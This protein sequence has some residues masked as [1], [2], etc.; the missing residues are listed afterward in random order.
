[1]SSKRAWS[2]IWTDINVWIL[3]SINTFNWFH[4]IP[5][6]ELSLH[7]SCFWSSVEALLSDFYSK[8]HN[9]TLS[10]C[11]DSLLRQT[12]FWKSRVRGDSCHDFHFQWLR[13]SL[14][15]KKNHRWTVCRFAEYHTNI[16]NRLQ[17]E[18]K[19]RSREQLLFLPDVRV[20]MCAVG[21]HT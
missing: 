6:V 12:L 7:T 18:K 1:M 14:Q 11:Q 3:H 16:L 15:E 4:S 10:A 5:E 19:A 21:R 17:H 8:S 9:S 20:K 13:L 2:S